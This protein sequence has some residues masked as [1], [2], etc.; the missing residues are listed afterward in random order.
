MDC[1]ERERLAAFI[2]GVERSA[3]GDPWSCGQIY[4]SLGDNA[5]AVTSEHGYALGVAVAG[6]AELYRMAVEPPFRRRGEGKQLLSAFA[7]RCGAM[8]CRSVYLEVR[9]RNA[10]AVS[11]YEAAGF[12]RVGE[13]KGYYGDD[14]ALLM[15]KNIIVNIP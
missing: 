10:A 8:G 15:K 5:V 3:F 2:A 12:V 9:S 6:E 14:D 13:R 11:L 7:E 4:D 1:C